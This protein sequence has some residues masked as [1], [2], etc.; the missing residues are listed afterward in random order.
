[1]N[2]A[3]KYQLMYNSNLVKENRSELL[4]QVFTTYPELIEVS[5]VF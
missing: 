4:V 1:M 5:K 2:K 3:I